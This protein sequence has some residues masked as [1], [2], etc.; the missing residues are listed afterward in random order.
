MFAEEYLAPNYSLINVY[1]IIDSSLLNWNLFHLLE[2]FVWTCLKIKYGIMRFFLN[3]RHPSF[4]TS[5]SCYVLL[6][7][8]YKYSTD[9]SHGMAGDLWVSLLMFDS[10]HSF[11]LNFSGDMGYDLKVLLSMFPLKRLS[12]QGGPPGPRPAHHCVGDCSE[13]VHS[14][15]TGHW[16]P[17]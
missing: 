9:T 3:F 12:D 6:R 11:I 5:V 13:S 15:P 17:C 7:V 10:R 2:N 4:P 8:R 1:C 16:I 14:S